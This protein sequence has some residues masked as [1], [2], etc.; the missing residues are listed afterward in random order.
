MGA[1]CERATVHGAHSGNGEA[2]VRVMPTSRASAAAISPSRQSPR[3]LMTRFAEAGRDDTVR[4]LCWLRCPTAL[5]PRRFR[6]PVSAGTAV[7]VTPTRD[8]FHREA[9]P[10]LAAMVGASLAT[11]GVCSA[12]C[13]I[14]R[15]ARPLGVSSGALLARCWDNFR[16]I[17]A[18]RLVVNSA[19]SPGRPPARWRL[20]IPC[21]RKPA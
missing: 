21:H 17:Y 5:G 19:G 20:S 3:A 9:A 13:K 12:L 15:D 8:L 4:L 2:V 11:S 6:C 14:R 1:S 16:S 18:R 10:V 7:R